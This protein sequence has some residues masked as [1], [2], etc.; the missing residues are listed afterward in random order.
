MWRVV[1]IIGV[2][3]GTAAPASA[4]PARPDLLVAAVTQPPRYVSPGGRFTSTVTVANDGRRRARESVVE[5]HVGRQRGG[6]GE[7]G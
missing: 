1:G 3:L 7:H 2:V 6:P 4:A 5:L